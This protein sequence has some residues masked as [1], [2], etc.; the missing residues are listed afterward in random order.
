M[1]R[2]MT[3]EVTPDLPASILHRH[4]NVEVFVDDEAM[5]NS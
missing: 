4:P 5:P 2:L 3:G 1:T